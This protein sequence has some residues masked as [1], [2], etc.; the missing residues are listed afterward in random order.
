MAKSKHTWAVDSIEEGIARV[1]QDGTRMLTVPRDLLPASA[2]E[3]HV[4]S[5]ERDSADPQRMSLIITVD[6]KATAAALQRSAA[7]TQAIAAASR[8]RDPGGDVT[9]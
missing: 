4:L 2:R 6:E 9:L 3:G 8:K 7:S 5:V 1:E